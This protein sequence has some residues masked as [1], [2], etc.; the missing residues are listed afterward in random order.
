MLVG[1][2][3]TVSALTQQ[4]GAGLLSVAVVVIAHFHK[5]RPHLLFREATL[6]YKTKKCNFCF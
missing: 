5:Q 1:S 4:I 2:Y 3:P 6:L